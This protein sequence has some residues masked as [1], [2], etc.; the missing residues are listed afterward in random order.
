MKKFI[1]LLLALSMILSLAACGKDP[2][3][4]TPAASQ[5][6]SSTAAETPAE[7]DP[8]PTEPTPAFDGDT[9]LNGAAGTNGA[10]ACASNLA[11]DIA[12]QIMEK[13]GNAV[14][15]AVAMIY[16]V[17]LLE[18]AASGIGGAGQMVIYLAESNEYVSIE[19]MTQAPGAAWPGALD[20]S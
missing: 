3:S 20:V 8:Q 4:S 16:A 5:P 17:G 14:D 1:S 11:S 19:Y 13:G 9:H 6:Q 7:T 18:P 15:A 10:A 2:A 12:V